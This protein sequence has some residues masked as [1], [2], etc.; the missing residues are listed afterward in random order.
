MKIVRP[1]FNDEVRVMRCI[2]EGNPRNGPSALN[3]F[4]SYPQVFLELKP[5]FVMALRV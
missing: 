3:H 2:K 1:T 4:E 5:F